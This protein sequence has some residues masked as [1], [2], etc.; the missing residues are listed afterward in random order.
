V[1]ALEFRRILTVVGLAI[2]ELENR[3]FRG[4]GGD[5]KGRKMAKTPSHVKS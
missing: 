3:A 4:A 5:L 2:V 1:S